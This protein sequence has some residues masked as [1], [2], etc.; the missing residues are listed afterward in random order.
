MSLAGKRM[1][2]DLAAYLLSLGLGLMLG[3]SLI[4]VANH[5]MGGS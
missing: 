1:D 3:M 5:L 4:S 2:D